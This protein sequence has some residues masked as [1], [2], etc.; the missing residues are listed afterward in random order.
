MINLIE[1]KIKYQGTERVINLSELKIMADHRL[2]KAWCLRQKHRRE[3]RHFQDI[4]QAETR[5]I[6]DLEECQ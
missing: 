4:E 6:K 5:R 2:K 3:Y 1:Q